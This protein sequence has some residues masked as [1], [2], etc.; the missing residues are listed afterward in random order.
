M[1]INNLQT[2]EISIVPIHSENGMVAFASAVVNNQF[3]IG[4]IAIYTSPSTSHGFRLVFPNKKL[5][6]GQSIDCFKPITR[7]AEEKLT[8][9][10][11]DRYKE[12][13]K[14]LID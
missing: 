7:D 9:D 1:S 11:V 14:E 8:K 10:I 5:S 3:F 2:S 4:N 6:S 13:I 12:I